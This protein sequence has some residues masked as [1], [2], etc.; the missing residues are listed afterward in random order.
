MPLRQSIST[1]HLLKLYHHPR[2]IYMGFNVERVSKLLK[3]KNC[4]YTRH[5]LYRMSFLF[6]EKGGGNILARPRKP[7][8]ELKVTVTF[9]LTKKLVDLIKSHKNYNRIV[10][11]AL[12]DKFDKK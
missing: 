2:K 6:L 12:K 1:K 3:G 4:S 10:E 5:V 7:P 11:D 8:E 9:R